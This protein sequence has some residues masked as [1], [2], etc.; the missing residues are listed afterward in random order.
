MKKLSLIC[1]ATLLL[2]CT[3]QAAA[4]P[5]SILPELAP[6]QSA[7]LLTQPI[8]SPTFADGK[9]VLEQSPALRHESSDCGD[10]N[11]TVRVAPGEN[12]SQ[13]SI[14]V[15]NCTN[16]SACINENH[17]YNNAGK[18]AHVT[19]YEHR[20]NGDVVQR[21]GGMII[22]SWNSCWGGTLDQ[23]HAP[24]PVFQVYFDS[25]VEV[26]VQGNNG[27]SMIIEVDAVP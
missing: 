16:I 27:L 18:S 2:A 20:S 7:N 19:F 23:Q 24:P 1:T 17:A 9:F 21:W 15:G 25:Q 3:T 11:F 6:V 10:V 26:L 13:S 8:P 5:K 14:P 4:V 22:G 12:K